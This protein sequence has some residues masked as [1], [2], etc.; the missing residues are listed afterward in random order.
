M[1][2]TRL[3][4]TGTMG[5]GK[6]SAAARLETRYGAKIWVR[7]ES[8]KRLSHA[9]ADQVG[10]VEALLTSLLPEKSERHQ[11]RDSLLRYISGYEPESGKKRRLYQDVT[12]I[13]MDVDPLA[14]ER[15]LYV[16]IL[17]AER[18][19]SVFSLVE[20]VRSVAAYHFFHSHGYP[21]LRIQASETVRRSRMLARDGYLPAPETF[22]HSS[23]TALDAIA[24]DHT[25]VNDGSDVGAFY[26]RLD[27]FVEQELGIQPVTYA[28]T[29]VTPPSATDER[30]S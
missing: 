29:G 12:Q 20:D 7:T 8:M 21:S 3:M 2:G 14:F 13:V 6:T 11:A 15:E 27:E 26:Q 17:E 22:S 24:H 5:S 28:T 30:N 16:R 25:L 4:M 19:S 1:N 10:D 18:D 23:E 9:L